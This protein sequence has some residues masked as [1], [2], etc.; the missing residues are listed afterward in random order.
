MTLVRAAERASDRRIGRLPRP[1]PTLT[2][3]TTTAAAWIAVLVA[4]FL[5]TAL[6]SP[7]LARPS[8]ADG[9]AAAGV[10]GVALDA[11]TRPAP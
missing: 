1:E 7:D 9:A 11:A 6:L 3:A 4:L 2:L 5:A 10:S 8:D